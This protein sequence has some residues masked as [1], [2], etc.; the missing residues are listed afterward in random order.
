MKSETAKLLW[1]LISV[2]IFLLV[3]TGTTFLVIT[4]EKRF[5][6]EAQQPGYAFRD[7]H[8]TTENSQQNQD[9]SDQEP[10][11]A[12]EDN[13]SSDETSGQQEGTPAL[14]ENPVAE[15]AGTEEAPKAQEP[16]PEKEQPKF[17]NNSERTPSRIVDRTTR[18]T[19]TAVKTQPATVTP[20]KQPTKPAERKTT[21]KKVNVNRYWIQTGSFNLL[22]GAENS[23]AD[24]KSKGYQASISTSTVNEKTWYRLRVG[25]FE[26]RN[27]ADYYLT[28]IKGLK[29]YSESYISKTTS[30][31]LIN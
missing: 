17:V 12:A 29:Q 28:K 22:S 19:E 27:E 6:S 16:A 3:I 11:F 26:S 14:Q 7:P 31:Q 30:T 4:G 8:E 13:A 10:S 25:P 20:V 9:Q 24:L 2:V 18:Q 5:A 21:P 1:I 23:K 15:F